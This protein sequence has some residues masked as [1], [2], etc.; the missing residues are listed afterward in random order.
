MFV[1]CS[2]SGVANYCCLLFVGDVRCCVLL[3]VVS[4]WCVLVVRGLLLLQVVLAGWLLRWCLFVVAGVAY[5]CCRLLSVFVAVCSSLVVVV[6]S[7]CFLF[8]S[9]SG[10]C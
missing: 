7:F 9:L 6:C 5:N 2:P 1:I 8:F 10:R 3:F 4:C